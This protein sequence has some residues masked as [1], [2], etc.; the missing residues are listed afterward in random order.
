MRS[1]RRER[2]RGPAPQ[3]PDR[4]SRIRLS[5][6]AFGAPNPRLGLCRLQPRCTSAF[7]ANEF[8]SYRKC[9]LCV[10]FEGMFGGTLGA[11]EERGSEGRG[12]PGRGDGED[13][14]WGLWL[15]A[16]GGRRSGEMRFDVASNVAATS[17]PGSSEF[18]IRANDFL[19]SPIAPGVWQMVV[20]QGS[21]E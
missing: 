20:E 18:R 2:D 3:R 4:T 12:E 5:V 9:T 6:L 21:S 1:T 16:V 15:R 13:G 7:R 14:G 10:R 19:P 17:T 11:R 8:T